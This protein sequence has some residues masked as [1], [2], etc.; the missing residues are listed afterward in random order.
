MC[1]SGE[2]ECTTF[3]E[4]KDR[5]INMIMLNYPDFKQKFYLQADASNVALGVSELHQRGW[6][7]EDDCICQLG[8][9]YTEG[10]VEHCVNNHEVLDILIR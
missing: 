2:K 1:K 6:R 5:F 3:Q 9:Q 8:T 7:M 10:T 4:I